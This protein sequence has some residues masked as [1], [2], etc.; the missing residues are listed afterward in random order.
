MIESWL[1]VSVNVL[2]IFQ[3]FSVSYLFSLGDVEL[4][5]IFVVCFSYFLDYCFLSE[6]SFSLIKFSLFEYL[7][8]CRT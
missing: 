1:M 8:C 3:Y 7:L 5:L 6:P 2:V 4:I